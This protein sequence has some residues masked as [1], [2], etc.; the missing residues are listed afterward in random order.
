MSAV[1]GMRFTKRWEFDLGEPV[2]SVIPSPD[3]THV[4]VAAV[5][6][7]IVVLA[8]GDGAP[9]ARLAG[10]DLGTKALDWS[11][12]SSY[13]V[14]C[15]Q[16][17]L[18]RVW[19]VAGGSVHVTVD[20]GS[21]WGECVAAAARY[22]AFATAAGR[23][24][25]L[26]SFDGELLCD[27]PERASTVLDVAWR[28]GSG[29]SRLAAASYGAIG[30]YDPGRLDRAVRELRWKG[31]SLKLAWSPD[32]T[33]LAT[34]DQDA[35]VHFWLVRTGVDLMM[36]G[37][38]RKVRE[39]AWDVTG[40]WL[41]TGGGAEIIVWDCS[42]SP[43]GSEPLVLEH[44]EAPLCNLAYQRRGGLLASASLDGALAIWGPAGS[45]EPVASLPGD[46]DEITTI[47]W[48]TGD[49]LVVGRH[50]GSIVLWTT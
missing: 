48:T 37:Y 13:V 8:A 17:G 33:Y 32:G 31:S 27:W 21:R 22:D 30:L 41:A 24:V 6:G 29:R 39:L 43:E 26:W 36:S 1:A 47:A 19:S 15:G 28:P 14:S 3:G 40:R 38:P 10:H 5:E 2:R 9:V 49:D 25:R 35:S 46:D 18:G 44:H 16:D 34:G 20:L 12:D 4:A 45:R 7:P 11:R 42:R 23:K 50:G